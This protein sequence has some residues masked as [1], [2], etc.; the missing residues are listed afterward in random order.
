[1]TVFDGLRRIIAYND[2][3]SKARQNSD[4][5]HELSHGLLLHESTPALD[6]TT[7]CRILV[8]SR[9]HG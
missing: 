3:H 5:S 6:M 4:L 7:G 9:V 1:M 8:L 2:A